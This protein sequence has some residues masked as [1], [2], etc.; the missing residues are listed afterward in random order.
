MR[1]SPLSGTPLVLVTIALS[2]AVFM[3]VLDSTIANVAL[4]TIAGNLGAA[5][6]QGT[7]VI[8]SF[9]VANAISVPLTG[10]LARRYGEV[11]VFVASTLLFVVA[12]F[13]CGIAPSLGLLVLFRVIQGAVAGPMIPLSQSLLMAA[14]PPEKRPMALALWSMVIIVAPI[15]GPILGGII[16]DNWHWGW[17]FFI[18][19]PIGIVAGWVAWRQLKHRET[20]I[21]HQPI[22]RLGLALMVVGVGAL[23]MMLDR[24]RELDWFS[25]TEIIVLAVL[26]VVCLSYFVIWEWYAEHPIVDLQLF[27]D[28][29]FT[30]G[31]ITLSTAFMVYMGAI[32]LLPLVLQTQLGYTATWAGLATAPIGIFPVLLSPLIGKFGN[33]LDM[34]ALV[35]VSFLVYAGCF[36]WRSEFN[37]QMDFMDVFWPQ[38]IQG[39]G[40][41]MFFMP[42]TQI[43]LSRIPGNQI[44]AASSISNFVRILAGGIGT[45]LVTTMWDRREALHH[46]RLVESINPYNDTANQ[47]LN[48]MGQMGMAAPQ[49]YGMLER[50]IEQQTN[51]MGANDIFWLCGVTF[52]ALVVLVWF[53]K[54]PF[55]S[56]GG[57]GAH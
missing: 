26:A 15:F 55:G 12:S 44:A 34:R 46:S 38:F 27:R 11:K 51:I 21:V 32:V 23:Q 16:S 39:I 47:T 43:T 8:T 52:V 10:W 35:T 3:Q 49:Q 7:W 17:I 1:V 41:A 40:M 4:P 50:I 6:N 14:Y 19:I 13:L 57:G 9:A 45:S 18:N 22:D 24:G 5:T 36:F 25:S 54:P 53:A 2:L 30:V 20:E 42:L 48:G 28:R 31:V 37:A 33:R 29:N 56:K